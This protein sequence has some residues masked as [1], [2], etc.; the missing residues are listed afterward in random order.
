MREN[1]REARNEYKS[2]S[3]SGS[4]NGAILYH[5]GKVIEKKGEE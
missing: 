4:I 2:K 5:K 1:E 3:G